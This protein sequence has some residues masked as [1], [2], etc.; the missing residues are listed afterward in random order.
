MNNDYYVPGSST[1]YLIRNIFIIVFIMLIAGLLYNIHQWKKYHF[2]MGVTSQSSALIRLFTGLLLSI[3]PL[4]FIPQLNNIS[5]N[6]LA[7]YFP[8]FAYGIIV[9]SCIGII[10]SLIRYEGSYAKKNISTTTRS[11][12]TDKY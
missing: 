8:D 11:V 3:A 10:N 1:E 12:Q 6:K 7:D 4:F 9:L 2:K 5:L